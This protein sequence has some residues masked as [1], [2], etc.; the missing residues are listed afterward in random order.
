MISTHFLLFFHFTSTILANC[1]FFFL[2][3]IFISALPMSWLQSFVSLLIQFFFLFCFS[4]NDCTYYFMR[5]QW[6]Q[7]IFGWVKIWFTCEIR[8]NKQENN[9][10]KL[11]IKKKRKHSDIN[12]NNAWLFVNFF[13]CKK[14][15]KKFP[16]FFLSN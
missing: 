14:K 1:A 12:V 9:K 8:A 10:T 13:I 11:K 2:N 3:S 6:T 15:E 16:M 5:M 4:W 7:F